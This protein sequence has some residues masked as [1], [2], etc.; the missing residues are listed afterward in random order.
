MASR[1][2]LCARDDPRVRLSL[3]GCPRGVLNRRDT[4]APLADPQA[5]P[6][7]LTNR[8]ALRGRL[9]PLSRGH[10]ER[11]KRKAETVRQS[12]ERETSFRS[13]LQFDSITGHPPILVKS[14][15]YGPVPPPVD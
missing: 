6:A 2:Y 3:S 7:R 11:D 10:P 13:V 12:H 9:R 1:Q 5:A 14:P 4:V 8:P 15:T